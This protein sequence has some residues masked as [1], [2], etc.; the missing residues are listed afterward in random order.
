MSSID[1]KSLLL[2]TH[3][4][5][6]AERGFESTMTKSVRF[7]TPGDEAHEP[8]IDSSDLSP[9]SRSVWEEE[10]PAQYD[11]RI[12]LPP[13]RPERKASCELKDAFLV[14]K[15]NSDCD[16]DD[17][18]INP[19]ASF[20]HPIGKGNEKIPQMDHSFVSPT[21]V[22]DT[23][24]VSVVPCNSQDSWVTEKSVCQGGGE[25]LDIKLPSMKKMIHESDDRE[26]NCS[27]RKSSDL[28]LVPLLLEDELNVRSKLTM[29]AR[30]IECNQS[31]ALAE[32]KHL[33]TEYFKREMILQEQ[34]S[35][36]LHRLNEHGTIQFDGRRSEDELT[37]NDLTL[38][39]ISRQREQIE[40][41]I[42]KLQNSQ[43]TLNQMIESVEDLLQPT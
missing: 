19:R 38:G 17:S 6:F 16:D 4:S 7:A 35:G 29:L 25:T 15:D 14:D 5:S 18:S 11:Q 22:A 24:S 31:Q 21:S 40:D 9:T 2:S 36:R 34:G 23:T 20:S 37:L 28:P 8:K 41:T 30:K 3:K 1:H 26:K 39:A 12:V 13:R 27:R 43:D 10:F 32:K 33:E 42:E